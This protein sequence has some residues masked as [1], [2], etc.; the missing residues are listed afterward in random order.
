MPRNFRFRIVVSYIGV[1]DYIHQQIHDLIITAL[2]CKAI[3]SVST[4]VIIRLGGRTIDVTIVCD[5]SFMHLY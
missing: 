2:L 1:L 3:K 4:I 5:S